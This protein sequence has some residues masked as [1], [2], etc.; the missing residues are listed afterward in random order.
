MAQGLGH[1]QVGEAQPRQFDGLGVGGP[2]HVADDHQIGSRGE[3][4][5]RVAGHHLDAQAGEE[6]GH[7]RVDV[8]VRTGDREAL[9]LEH[10]GHGGHA[11][12]ADA[13]EVDVTRIGRGDVQGRIKQGAAHLERTVRSMAL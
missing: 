13:D 4:G 1:G 6:V 7:R 11:G 5:G 12:A 10:A 3:I 8:L 2:D 9:L